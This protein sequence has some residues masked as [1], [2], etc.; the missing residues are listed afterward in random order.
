MSTFDFN[1]ELI[2]NTVFDSSIITNSEIEDKDVGFI[3]RAQ[4]EF[5]KI[6]MIL[7]LYPG[8]TVMSSFVDYNTRRY[9][10][11]VHK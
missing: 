11:T 2:F 6:N 7:S 5:D 1:H 3:Q 9:K 4:E 8:V 10:I